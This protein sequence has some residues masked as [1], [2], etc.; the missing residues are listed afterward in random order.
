MFW[1]REPGRRVALTHRKYTVAARKMKRSPREAHLPAAGPIPVRGT[2]ERE[3]SL[4][5]N[6]RVSC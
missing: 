2:I 4:R 1:S 5:V 3:V 6:F